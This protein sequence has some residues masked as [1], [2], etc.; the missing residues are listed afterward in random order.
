MSSGYIDSSCFNSQ[1]ADDIVSFVKEKRGLGLKYGAEERYLLHFDEYVLE[2]GFNGDTITKELFE[3]WTAQRPHEKAK[4]CENRQIILKGLCS[5]IVRMGGTA[6]IPSHMT[7][8]KEPS[9]FRAHIYTGDELLRFLYAVDNMQGSELRRHVFSMFFRLLICTGL[10]LSEALELRRGDITFNNGKAVICIKKAKYDKQRLVPL[11]KD[12]SSMLIDYLEKIDLFIPETD[13]VFPNSRGTPY[14][15]SNVYMTFRKVL[16]DAGISH[17]GQKYGPRIHD[18]RHTFAVRS[19]RKLVLDGED[20]RV[21]IPMLCQYLGHKNIS[22]TQ[23]YLQFTADMFPQVV[24]QEE[25]LLG[26][27]IP[28]LEE[29]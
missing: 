16:W 23:T 4:T 26:N 25:E 11:T 13:V 3:N 15:S 28:R 7:R 6:Y 24:S 8:I 10:R 5:Y 1:F 17:G 22:A 20:L 29:L 9:P 19:L 18:F 21:V 12:M 27:I 2:V 14:I